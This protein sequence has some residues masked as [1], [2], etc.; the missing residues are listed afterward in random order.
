MG[1]SAGRG[2]CL[3]VVYKSFFACLNVGVIGHTMLAHPYRVTY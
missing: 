1:S 3:F 2:V